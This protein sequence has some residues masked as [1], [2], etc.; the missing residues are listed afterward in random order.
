M[1]MQVLM[2]SFAVTGK[3][4]VPYL[5]QLMNF[6]LSAVTSSTSSYHAKSLA[7]SAVG[8]AGNP[9]S[10]FATRVILLIRG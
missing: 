7:I 6:L 8:A 3:D 4:I 1:L 9:D 10:V 2:A 5:P